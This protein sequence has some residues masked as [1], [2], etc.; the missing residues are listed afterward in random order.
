MRSQI[1]TLIVF[2]LISLGVSE[3]SARPRHGDIKRHARHAVPH[4]VYEPGPS[5]SNGWYEHDSN[6]LPFGSSRWW[7]QML[8]EDRV[9][10]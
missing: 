8:R 1:A 6:K 9:P 4:I 5:Q 2:S 3:A 10:N 7:Q